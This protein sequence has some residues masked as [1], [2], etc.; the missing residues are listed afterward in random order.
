MNDIDLL[1]RVLAADGRYAIL[2]LNGKSPI[3]KLVDT[4]E[5][6]DELAREYVA[7]GRD[8]YFGCSKFG[9]ENNRT[10]GNVKSIK[11]FWIDLDCGE[12]K[13]IV[14]E[15]TNRPAGYIDQ[16]TA[17]SELSKFCDLIGLPPPLL[18]NSGR[19][20]HAYWPLKEAV[21][22]A[23]WEPVA[24]RL[25]ELCN[26]HNLYV[27][28]SVFEAAR[29][30]RVPGTLNFKDTPPKSV[31]VLR[32]ADDI[33]YE[34]IRAI[35][36]V[37]EAKFEPRQ[38]KE[39]SPLA[40]S[41]RENKVFK[42]SKIMVRSAKEEGCQQL[43]YCYQNQDSIPEPLWF[44]A[45]SIA[46]RCEDRDTAI[47]KISNQY[48]NYTPE[49]TEAKANH[50]ESAHAC[51]T[52]EKNNPG[53]CDGC[54]WKGR[55]N[56]P[57][58]LGA[59]IVE[60]DSDEVTEDV[61]GEEEVTTYK[62]PPYPNPYFRGKNG[63]I[64]L[65]PFDKDDEVEPI[66]V[67][68]HDLYIVKRMRDPDPNIGN[69]VL[70]RLH[71]PRDGVHEF[72]VPLSVISVKE[73]LREVL[74]NNGVAAMPNQMKEL[75]NFLM[76]FVKEDQY[77]TRVEQMRNQFG[78]ADRD[79]KF[80]IGNR[81]ITKDGMF[82]SP[83]S[84]QTKMFADFMVPKGTF[85]KWKEVF[86]IYGTPGL[87]ANAFAALSAFGAPLFKFTGHKGAIINLI[88]TTSGTGKSTA[89]YMANSVYGHPDG[90]AA[91]ARDTMAA[92]MIQLGVMNNIPFTVDEITNMSPADFS[93]LA[94]AMSQ[95]RGANRAKAAVNELRANST[96]WQTISVATS[97]A[98]FYE[99][100]GIHKSDPDGEMMRLLEYK[101]EPS[102]L[103]PPHI[104]KEM[105]DH[106]LKENYGHAGDIYVK[107]L[108]DN[109][110]E[111]VNGMRGIQQKI[112]KEMNLTGRERFWSATIACNIAGGM[113]ARNLGLLDW[114]MKLIYKWAC[115]MLE[116]LRED[117][118]APASNSASVVGDFINRH[119][120]NILVVND[121]ADARTN[122]HALPILEPR[123]ELL[124]RYEPDTK[125]MYILASAFRKDCVESQ[126]HYKDTLQQLEKKGI[127][128]GAATKRL[129]KGMKVKS[130]GVHALQFDCSGS[131]FIDIDNLIIPEAVNAD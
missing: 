69:L 28:A 88:H 11:A 98:S 70:L 115:A 122:M 18:V 6:F 22:R 19:G 80:I 123:G 92:K 84:S 58:S 38:T 52:F 44:D 100:L 127:Y 110:E 95:G 76:K 13:A 49:R 26:I 59:E 31:S 85:E 30:L 120:Q 74:A 86:N 66:C 15:K 116:G 7:Q 71:L 108:V 25:N 121:E 114:D 3:Q 55:I 48:H 82:H 97:N 57:L 8:V 12:A 56:T 105:F 63:G 5:E 65:M 64:Y 96:T 79:S 46:H 61:E 50:S 20:I 87:E 35:L 27:D 89:L 53:G 117:V 94:Y 124:I 60:A 73:Q 125:K 90:L 9:D 39:L 42:F 45:L 1:S 93:N 43:L 130:P 78:W 126:T 109:L 51:V 23:V 21:S 68:E 131:E 40:Q 34:E 72:V 113:L 62:I 111:A 67:Y 104:A 32:D 37:K 112:D 17:I 103:I 119:M 47:H 2:G 16:E 106:Q 75:A 102:N 41:L 14:N 107:Y 83:P 33:G 128:M 10:K 91:I 81:E 29:V 118:K 36:G 4:R 99:K 77:I 54:K 101:I 24:A 129:S